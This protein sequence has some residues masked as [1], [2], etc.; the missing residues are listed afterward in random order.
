VTAP[1]GRYAELIRDHRRRVIIEALAQTRGN[2][3]DAAR[4]LDLSRAGFYSLCR[5]L[6]VEPRYY[7]GRWDDP[8][9]SSAP[10]GPR[11]PE[12]PVP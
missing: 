11:A 8:P 7:R 1:R 3:R 6:G 12:H 2:V 5:R 9:T 10:L 4:L